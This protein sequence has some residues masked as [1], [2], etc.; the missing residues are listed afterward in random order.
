M[1]GIA[2]I[3]PILAEN[4]GILARSLVL[5][6]IARV[7]FGLLRLS[8]KE[9]SLLLPDSNLRPILL[10]VLTCSLKGA[11]QVRMQQG[12]LYARKLHVAAESI[13]NPPAFCIAL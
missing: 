1:R 8:G 12:A 4:I 10:E 6:H 7:V 13:Q 2:R 3:T 9:S 5:T 11:E